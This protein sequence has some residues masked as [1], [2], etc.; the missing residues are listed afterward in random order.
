VVWPQASISHKAHKEGTKDD[1][2]EINDP[3]ELKTPFVLFV[4]YVLFVAFLWLNILVAE[5]V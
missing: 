5:I 4:R 3:W 1:R 2:I